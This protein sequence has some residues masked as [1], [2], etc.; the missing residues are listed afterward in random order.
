MLL[1]MLGLEAY[2]PGMT[3]GTGGEPGQPGCHL[4]RS[5][6]GSDADVPEDQ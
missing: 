5:N 1:I 3:G 2:L 4:P 6:P